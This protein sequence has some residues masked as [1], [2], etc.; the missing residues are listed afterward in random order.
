MEAIAKKSQA[1][2]N[3]SELAAL[4]NRVLEYL[5]TPP[6][7]VIEV[8]VHLGH[9][10]RVWQEAFNP[11]LIIG[12]DIDITDSASELESDK[13]VLIKGNST[14]RSVINKVK[15][16]L[17]GRKA[18]FVFI[19]GDHRLPAVASDYANFQRLVNTPAVIAL[20]DAALEDH[21]LVHVNKWWY[22]TE[23]PYEREII[24]AGGT[25]VG[26]IYR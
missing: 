17:D 9:S 15:K 20:H 10:I 22:M 14:H 1:S 7:V 5:P 24:H 25:G 2:Q 11:D 12:I 21:N 19:D 23:L 3:P 8:G 18:D 16:S 6:K 13:V 4:L 26:V